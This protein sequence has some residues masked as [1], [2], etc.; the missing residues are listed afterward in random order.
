MYVIVEEEG[1]DRL[2][3]KLE[4]MEERFE[5]LSIEFSVGTK[6]H[7]DYNGKYTVTNYV[8]LVHYRERKPKI[9]VNLGYG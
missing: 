7:Y 3:K 5:I 6:E 2:T 4:N 9:P 8:A 1:R